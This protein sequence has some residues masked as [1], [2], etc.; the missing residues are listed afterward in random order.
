MANIALLFSILCLSFSQLICFQA[1]AQPT[2]E[3]T[4]GYDYSSGV[5]KFEGEAYI[6]SGTTATSVMQV[7]GGSSCAITIMLRVYDGSITV[8]RTPVVLSNAYNRWFKVNVIHDVG[9]S[10]LKVYIDSALRYEGFGAGGNN[11]Y[12]KFGVYAEEGAS[13]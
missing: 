2:S 1:N 13:I 7:F 11:H 8:Y 6:S 5:W 12:F 4:A 10:N 3:F 9:V